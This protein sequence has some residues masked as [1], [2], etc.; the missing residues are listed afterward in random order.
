MAATLAVL[1]AV[2]ITHA[3]T[4]RRYLWTGAAIGLAASA[5]YNAAAVVI[6]LVVAHVLAHRRPLAERR[7]LLIA[8]AAAAAVFAVV[9]LGG[10]VHPLDFLGEI[11]SEGAH[12]RNGH[13]GSEGNSPAFNATWL[14]WSFGLALPL[15]ACSLLSPRLRRPARGDRAAQLRSRLLRV[16]RARSPSGSR[17]TCSPSR[18][19]SRPR[20]P[21]GSSCACNG[22]WRPV[23]A[24]APRGGRPPESSW[25]PSS[26]CR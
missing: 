1:G 8:A 10:T 20:P 24:V 11:G 15:A 12:Y 23:A 13:F 16:P 25:S 21:S 19:P 22:W 7:P 6:A 9:N 3:P 2:M 4:T 18:E 26:R 14:W 17:A 5:K